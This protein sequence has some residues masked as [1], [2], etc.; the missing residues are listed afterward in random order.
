MNYV[1]REIEPELKRLIDS[2]E[3]HKNVI[4]VDG[5]RQV[6]KSRLVERVLQSNQ[7]KKIEINL[8]VDSLVRSKIDE[9]LQFNEF[10]DLLVDEFGLDPNRKTIIYIDEA[11]ESMK[12]GGFVRSMKEQWPRVTVILTGSSLSR[13]FRLG[14]RYPVGRVTNLTIRP[15]SFSEYLQ[16]VGRNDL[17]ANIAEGAPEVSRTRHDTLLRHLDRYLLTGGLPD[18]V[19]GS[20]EDDTFS[21]HQRQMLAAYEQD[22]RRLF[23]EDRLHLAQDCLRS[24]ANLVGFPSKLS[25][26]APHATTKILNDVKKVFVRLEEWHIIFKSLQFGPSVTASYNYLPKRYMFDTGILRYIRETAVPSIDVVKTLDTASRTPLGGVIENQT[27]VDLVSMGFD[28]S[29]W[30]KSPSGMEID[31]VV[32]RRKHTIPIECKA[33]LRLNKKHLK[34]LI[35]Y[36]HLHQLSTGVVV[37]LTPFQRIESNGKTIFNLPLYM[38]RYLIKIFSL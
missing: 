3:E 26:V 25:S 37:S 20:I 38:L 21:T 11:Q 29:G 2:T 31:F 6:G 30:K 9:C 7:A 12:L 28:I 1:P 32:K 36:L 4:L 19:S 16:A 10:Y 15:F 13:L 14:A 18:I 8:E 35:E 27:A 34:G 5:A 17:A 22:F 33:T 24:V 23:G